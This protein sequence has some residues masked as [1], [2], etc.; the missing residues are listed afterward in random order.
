MH[1]SILKYLTII[2]IAIALQA[3]ATGRTH[4]ASQKLIDEGATQLNPEEV[5]GHLSGNT[6]VWAEGGA[7][8]S[9]D[10]GLYVKWQGKIFPERNWAVDNNGRVCIA[11]PTGRVTSCSEYFLKDGKVWAVTLEV[12]GESTNIKPGEDKIRKG[13][14][15][16]D[17]TVE[18]QL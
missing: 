3:C 14:V 9:P 10:G 5:V 11:E 1:Q 17:L 12:F 16:S 8:F 4:P 7:Y 6:Q 18:G 13:N 15:L 2:V